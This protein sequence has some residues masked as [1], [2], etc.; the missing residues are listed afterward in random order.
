MPFVPQ[1]EKLLGLSHFVLV[2]L[3]P[4][5]VP[6]SAAAAEEIKRIEKLLLDRHSA[7]SVVFARETKDA[8][9]LLERLNRDGKE[10]LWSHGNAYLPRV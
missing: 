8:T 2:L 1:V 9:A 5:G 10:P 4:A 7:A 3:P 6:L